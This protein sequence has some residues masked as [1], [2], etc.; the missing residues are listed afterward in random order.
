MRDF[1]YIYDGDNESGESKMKNAEFLFP[2]KTV[3]K[4]SLEVKP[5]LLDLASK[6][7]KFY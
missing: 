7:K 6:T 5:S 1:L 3:G 2:K 4:T